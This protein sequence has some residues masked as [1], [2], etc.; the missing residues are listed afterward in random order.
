MRGLKLLIF[1]MLLLASAP[2][3]LI[4][5]NLDPAPLFLG[6][7][8]CAFLGVVDFMSPSGSRGLAVSAGDVSDASIL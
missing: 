4:F 8:V 2:A 3:L 7:A 6:G 5:S 1:G